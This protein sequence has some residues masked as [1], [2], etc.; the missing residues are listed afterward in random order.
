MK[1][2][3]FTPGPVPVPSEVLVEMAKPIIHHRTAEFESIFEEVREGLKYIYQTEE[4]VFVLASSGTGAME[5]AVVNTLSR[6]DKVLV[7]NGGKFGE[8][9]GKIAKAYG[10]E[11]EEIVVEWGTA[12]EPGQIKE[13]LDNGHSS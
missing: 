5:A 4:E 9:W 12:V 13:A 8:R 10:L 2:Y 3:V 1:K 11:V 7:V 6:G